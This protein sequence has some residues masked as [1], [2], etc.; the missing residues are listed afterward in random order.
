MSRGSLAAK[1]APVGW[2]Q[3]PDGYTIRWRR[4]DPV[5]HVLVGQQLD[6]HGT[7]GVLATIPVSPSG[8]TDLAQVRLVGQRWL[9][10]QRTQQSA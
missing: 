9:H 6:N 3:L 7:A 4:G 1:T 10:R 8:W 5:A 2:V